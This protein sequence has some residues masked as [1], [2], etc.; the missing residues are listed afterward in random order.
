MLST[1]SLS[2]SDPNPLCGLYDKPTICHSD[3]CCW[4][5]KS[6][7]CLFCPNKF[8]SANYLWPRPSRVSVLNPLKWLILLSGIME[9][10]L[11]QLSFPKSQLKI[12]KIIITTRRLHRT[13]SHFPSSLSKHSLSSSQDQFGDIAVLLQYERKYSKLNFYRGRSNSGT[14]S[15]W[16]MSTTNP[17]MIKKEQTLRHKCQERNPL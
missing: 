6:S 2:L 12:N 10:I 14:T 11:N 8:T 13:F 4:E 9:I 7:V 17:P 3:R 16:L 1:E 15:W 5:E